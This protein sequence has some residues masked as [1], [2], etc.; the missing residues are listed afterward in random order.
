[1]YM[2]HL[3]LTNI[4]HLY[5]GQVIYVFQ[6]V[7]IYYLHEKLD[8]NYHYLIKTFFA[9]SL[10][11]SNSFICLRDNTFTVAFLS[12]TH[13]NIGLSEEECE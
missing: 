11:S 7:C 3:Y 2:Y 5:F 1:M 9:I 4:D 10:K 12:D 8:I 6:N 13:I